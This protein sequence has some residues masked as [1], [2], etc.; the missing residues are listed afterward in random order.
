[1]VG[2]PDEV[3]QKI[4]AN[5]RVPE[6]LGQPEGHALMAAQIVANPHL[7]GTPSRLDG[8]MSLPPR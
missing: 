3:S 7:N 8:A 2:L 1:M 5:I 6:R 4:A